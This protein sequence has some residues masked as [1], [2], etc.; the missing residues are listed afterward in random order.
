MNM[1]LKYSEKEIKKIKKKYIKKINKLEE[2][3]SALTDEELKNMTNIFKDRL[4][5]GETLDDIL[6]EAFAVVRE[7]GKR[8]LNMKHFEVQLIGGIVL[9]Q[10]RIAEM[11]TGEG[12]TLVA[13]LPA[14]LNALSGKG[15]HIVTVN[16]YLANRDREIM[17]PLY[18]FLGI[19]TAVI[20]NSTSKIMRKEYYK[21]DI[22]YITNT[23]LGFDYLRDNM[24]NDPNEKVQR[25][26]NYVIVDEVDS[27]LIDE[28]R[29][30]LIISSPS[31]KANYLYSI[32]D[33]FVKSL[34]EDEFEIYKE[35]NII[36]LTDKGISKAELIFNIDNYADIEH[37]LIRH[38]ITQALK[39]VYG[40]QKDK[41]Y[42]IKDG[43]VIIIDEFTGRLAN[44]R[45]YSNG[46]HQAIESK[47]GLEIQPESITL[48]TIT[49][50][51][52]FKLY[53][54]L[55]GM[56]GTAETEQEEF[57]TTYNLDVVV[58]PTNN[59]I[60]RQ[61]KNDLIFITEQ[62]KFKAIIKDIIENH[63][64]G[65]PVLV[66][67]PN[68]EKSEILSNLLKKEGIKHNVLNAKYHEEEANIISKA[69]ELGAVTI[70]TNMAGRGTDIKLSNEVK[71]IGGLKVIGSERAENR[72]VDNQ[73]IGRSGRQ[74]DPGISQFYLSFEDDL[75]KF[76]PKKY[77]DVIDSCNKEDE[78]PITNKLL[79]KIINIC[80]R[81]I[82]GQ[83]FQ[84]RKNTLKYDNV[85]NKQRKIVYSQRDEILNS[86]DLSEQLN[87]ITKIVLE[88]FI[89]SEINKQKNKNNTLDKELL[90]KSIENNFFNEGTFNIKDLEILSERQLVDYFYSTSLD[91][92]ESKKNLMGIENFNLLVKSIFIGNIDEYWREHL[93]AL[94]TLKE[95][96]RYMYVKGE[97]PIKEY[98]LRSY[99]IFNSM[100]FETQSNILK[101]ILK[102]TL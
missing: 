49:Y 70:A 31:E 28:A 85:I 33:V 45:R 35:N 55:S 24:V 1:F 5:K 47:E 39:A 11:K 10:G 90:I 89:T 94:E 12:K 15:V 40:M 51:N 44:G 56:T 81:K 102:F 13:T 25:G 20:V 77:R 2:N 59:P 92:L 46:L 21:A 63:K 37:N 38:H 58:I 53:N 98:I 68:I 86:T 14:Y 30:P 50:Q 34:N 6:P 95:D 60:Q 80:Q 29:T 97:E 67:T 41:D 82:E 43:Q 57:N 16:D 73:L 27:V 3:I 76:L 9:H 36:T 87:Y 83:H 72:R 18:D 4:S 52:F 8:V 96:V 79:T 42:M 65:R 61:D 71:Q 101:T 19:S 66:G 91:V 22:T 75:I 69:G 88:D 32:I 84:A 62:A 54:K 26:L 78:T 7:A 64:K 100:V 99:D 23:E 17:K 93:E 48:A 74:G